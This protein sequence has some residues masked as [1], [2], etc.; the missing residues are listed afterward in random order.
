MASIIGESIR[1]VFG[2]GIPIGITSF[3][4][5]WWAMKH[6]YFGSVS[7]LKDLE[8]RVK[9]HTRANKERKKNEKKNKKTAKSG[10]GE[11]TATTLITGSGKKLNLVHNKWLAF[12][13]GFYGVVALWTYIVIEL[14]EIRDFLVNL[15]GFFAMM[16][17]ISFE[18][19]IGL[20]INSLMNFVWA[21]AWPGYWIGE[22]RSDHVW[23]W[24]LVAY[25]AY[26]LGFKFALKLHNSKQSS[27]KPDN[28]SPS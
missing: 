27:D 21:I 23:V 17:N 6:E 14:V 11:I 15:G 7:S 19:L 16:S 28:Q 10:K 4:L 22:I 18:L 3:L 2:A 9:A 8:S 26:R 1:A 5:M 24:L 20:L 25:F 12:G 13:G